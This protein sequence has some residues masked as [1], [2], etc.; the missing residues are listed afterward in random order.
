M[1]LAAAIKY[2]IEKTNEEVVL[3]AHTH[4][5]I[6]KQLSAL[7]FEPHTGYKEIAQGFIN[8]NGE[9]LNRKDA[10][11]HAVQCGQIPRRIL[12]DYYWENIV[13]QELMSEDLW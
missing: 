5:A 8:D 13:G 1:I 4:S 7:G 3:C 12:N 9:F 10:F 2:R 11:L 6:I